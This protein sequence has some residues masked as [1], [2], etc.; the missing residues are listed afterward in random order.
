MN[1][2]VMIY[3]YM[4]TSC[5]LLYFGAR[6]K[7]L[8]VVVGVGHVPS[9]FERVPIGLLRI[10]LPPLLVPY[11]GQVTPRCKIQLIVS[12][13][14]GPDTTINNGGEKLMAY[15]HPTKNPQSS[16]R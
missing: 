1:D 11:V 16:N 12:Y 8:Q 15:Q 9:V 14:F 4:Y 3:M 13:I 6:F 2:V 10:S 5:E 7:S